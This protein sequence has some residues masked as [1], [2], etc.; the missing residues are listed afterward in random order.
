MIDLGILGNVVRDSE[1]RETQSGVSVCTFTVAVNDKYNKD[2]P[3]TYFRV[4]AWRKLAETCGKYVKRGMKVYVSCDKIEVQTYE[5]KKEGGT[6]Y[7]LAVQARDIEFISKAD[8]ADN[9]DSAPSHESNE[10]PQQEYEA[11]TDG[12]GFTD[13]TGDLGELP[14]D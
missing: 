13:V 8:S 7:N 4:T 12:S 9:A 1:L 3:T 14:F 5:S 10:T 6:K 2:A 11:Q